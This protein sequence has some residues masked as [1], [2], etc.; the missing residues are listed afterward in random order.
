MAAADLSPVELMLE[1]IREDVPLFN[2]W[3]KGDLAEEKAGRLVRMAEGQS[4]THK[5]TKRRDEMLPIE[6]LLQLARE[7]VEEGQ[8]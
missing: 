8:P 6:H 4:T 1:V 2:M 3:R 7:I 5:L